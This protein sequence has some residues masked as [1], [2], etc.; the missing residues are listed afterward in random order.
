[1]RLRLRAPVRSRLPA[2]AL[3][4][5]FILGSTPATRPSPAPTAPA[6][7]IAVN[8]PPNA[9][10]AER[11]AAIDAVR[12]TGAS[13]FAMTLSWSA[14]EPAPRQYRL[15]EITRTA[16]VLRQ[17]G[18]VLHLDLPL[19]TESDRDV[20]ADL[21]DV[22]FDDPK[23]SLRLGGLLDRLLPALLDFDTLSLGD[24]ADTYFANRP[25]ELRAYR[26]LFDGAVQFLSR[27]APHLLVGVATAS[28]NESPAPTVAAALHARSPLLLYD[29]APFER[30]RR[31]VQ[32]D[33]DALERDWSRLLSTAAGRPIGFPVVSYSSSEENGSSVERQAEFV[34]RMRDFLRRS[35]GRLLRFARYV[36]LR[37]PSEPAAGGDEA[38]ATADEAR[39]R[40]FLSHRGLQ[41]ANGKP[42]AAWREWVRGAAPVKK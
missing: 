3:S 35:D 36:A 20:P 39:R 41:E 6:L 32:R 33:P 12:R 34:R 24:G 40:A 9:S 19:V 29:Y 11:Q 5:P 38:D 14:A 30:G 37:D 25:D 23:L 16:R 13:F 26:R 42:K 15:E 28:P 10:P 18:A 22:A 31:F 27:R 4:L 8:L 1:M 2:L 7:G 21:A 17:S